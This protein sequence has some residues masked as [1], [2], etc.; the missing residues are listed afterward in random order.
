LVPIGSFGEITDEDGIN[1]DEVFPV[2]NALRVECFKHFVMV[3]LGL[4]DN[5]EEFFK[6]FIKL[7]CVLVVL[8]RVIITLSSSSSRIFIYLI[9]RSVRFSGS[10]L[11]IFFLSLQFCFFLQSEHSLRLCLWHDF[12]APVKKL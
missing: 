11:F 8:C 9:L 4:E 7:G 3:I 6:V 12:V 1:I 2:V 10:S 5:S